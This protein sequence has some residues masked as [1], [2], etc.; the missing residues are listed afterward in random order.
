MFFTHQQYPQKQEKNA[1]IQQVNIKLH[2]M[3]DSYFEAH[4]EEMK[5]EAIRGGIFPEKI[6][7]FLR[8]FKLEMQRQAVCRVREIAQ[9]LA[10]ES[11]AVS[12]DS[13]EAAYR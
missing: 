10:E 5:Q 12:K 3:V 6:D 8:K 11:H 1:G 2:H 4:Y 13:V 9:Q 7:D